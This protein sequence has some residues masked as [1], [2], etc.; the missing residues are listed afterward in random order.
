MSVDTRSLKTDTLRS[1]RRG[2]T[3]DVGSYYG[4]A[5]VSGKR[6]VGQGVDEEMRFQGQ[7]VDECS[8][9]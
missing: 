4:D 7:D 2:E 5:G 8:I 1:S 6:D 3:N 9:T